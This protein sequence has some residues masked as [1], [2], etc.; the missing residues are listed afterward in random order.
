MAEAPAKGAILHTAASASMPHAVR[1]VLRRQ[2]SNGRMQGRKIAI[3]KDG[4]QFLI[5][6]PTYGGPMVS[7]FGEVQAAMATTTLKKRRRNGMVLL[8]TELEGRG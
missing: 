4:L 2:L 5:A 6:T 1:A 3:G 7:L 8:Y